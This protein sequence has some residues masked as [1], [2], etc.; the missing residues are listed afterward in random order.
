MNSVNRPSRSLR[1]SGNKMTLAATDEFWLSPI[2]NDL[3]SN[4]ECNTTS[5]HSTT[6]Y[7]SLPPAHEQLLMDDDQQPSY[8]NLKGYD[9]AEGHDDDSL[10]GYETADSEG[11]FFCRQKVAAVKQHGGGSWLLGFA[12]LQ[13]TAGSSSGEAVSPEDQPDDDEDM[14]S[15]CPGLVRAG[16]KDS[17]AS[18][19]DSSSSDEESSASPLPSKPQSRGVSFSPAVK[20]QAVPHS[21]DLT[22]FQRRKMYSSS[23]EVRQNKIRNKKEYRYDGC[24]WRNITEE[25]EMGVDM[26]TGEL[27]HPA[28][29]HI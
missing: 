1:R 10:D 22:P 18:D 13:E 28:H 29:D 14:V 12:R 8:E 24:D 2:A 23:F 25:W 6:A 15:S 27:I 19:T 7:M 16:S 21:S 3:P 4:N 26:V 9:H 11:S 17:L 20:V 5:C